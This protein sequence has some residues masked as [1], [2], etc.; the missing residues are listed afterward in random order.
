MAEFAHDLGGECDDALGG[1]LAAPVLDRVHPGTRTYVRCKPK[2][3]H[4]TLTGIV[5]EAEVFPSD[6]PGVAGVDGMEAADGVAG[7]DAADG[8]AGAGAADGV[9]GADAAEGVEDVEFDTVV[10][11]TAEGQMVVEGT[12]AGAGT[13]VGGTY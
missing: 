4:H 7:A 6:D 3:T 9:A 1:E 8:V 11:G 10:C 2:L 13:G 5:G 12:A